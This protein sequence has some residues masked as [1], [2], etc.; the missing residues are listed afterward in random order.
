MGIQQIKY[1]RLNWVL[2]V[3][4]LLACQNY[5]S[6]IAQSRAGDTRY[7]AA[8]I[9]EGKEPHVRFSSGLTVADEVLWNGRWVNRYWL[10]TGMIKPEFHLQNERP[11]M[12]KLP[13]DAF[14]LSIENENL[15]GKWKWIR[16][17][18]KP[19]KNP[20]GLLVVIEL[21]ST[22]RPV[23]VKINTL[24]TG[25][26]VMVRW[27]EIT[28]TGNKPTAITKVSPW[29]GMLWSTPGYTERVNDDSVFEVGYCEYEQWG[30]EGAWK[31]EPIINGTKIVSGTRGKSGW[32]HP[33]FF[34]RNKATGEYFVGS[35]G[36]SGNWSIHLTGQQDPARKEARLFF[37]MGP[38]TVDPVLRT[39]DP[40]ETAKTPQTHIF[41]MQA[42]LDQVIQTLHDHVRRDV[43]LP[44]I[45]GRE[46]QVESNH[47]G[48]IVDH[49]NEAGLMREVDLATEVGAELFMIDAGWYGPEPNRW[50]RNVGDWYAGQWLPN[51]LTPVREYA[52]K[53][54]LLFGLWVEPESVGLASKLRIDHPDWVATRNGG[55]VANGR[56]LDLANPAV[57]KWVESEIVRI[58]RKY[59]LDMFRIDYNT[60][61]E[62]GPNRVKDGFVENTLWRNTEVIYGIFERVHKQ[63]PN[64]ILQNCAGGGGRLDLGMMSH[65]HNTELSDWMRAPRST[66]ILNG[67]TWILPPEIL[68]R[69]FG[70]EVGDHATDGNLD[71]QLRMVMMSR[72]IFRGISPSVAEF[73]PI[74]K[75]RIRDSMEFYKRTI[76]PI[77]VDSRVYHHTPLVPMMSPSPWVVLEYAS[78]DSKRAV[79]GLFR[80][81]AIGDPVYRF[82]ARGLD[83]ALNYRVTTCNSGKSFDISGAELM[84]NGIPVR[85]D[86]DLTSEM[87]VFEEKQ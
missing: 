52:R 55:P 42:G 24:L 32:G 29:S 22:T 79:V 12:E 36:W 70:T 5:S 14:D 21:A 19:V 71:Y 38:D 9:E 77:M 75:K 53:K 67:M 10:S 8:L 64:L 27:L 59:D 65:F 69:T 84:N 33:T 1:G 49:E 85:L 47:R 40:G 46:Y 23:T 20:D 45:P 48:Y 39:L 15:I 73:N 80:T 7:T 31:F 41:P 72:P 34:V 26:P 16:A 60:T 30:M 25:G 68:L 18:Q 56:Q 66:K 87:L 78:K 43:I 35:L 51:D 54:G 63:F 61:L 81:S 13:V 74:L 17:E 3:L 44:P 11:T 62:E 2:V 76:R 28:N 4:I 37:S 57:A 58:I 86:A 83:P 82:M 50:A 6:L